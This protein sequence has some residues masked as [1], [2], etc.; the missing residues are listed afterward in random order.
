MSVF[1]FY[2]LLLRGFGGAFVSTDKWGGLPLTLLLAGV[3]IIFSYPLGIILALA[4][5]QGKA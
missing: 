2:W 5:I 3:G 4:D 1:F